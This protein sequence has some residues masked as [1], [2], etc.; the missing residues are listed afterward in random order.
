[1]PGVDRNAVDLTGRR[2]RFP[3]PPQ[4]HASAGLFGVENLS[5]LPTEGAKDGTAPTAFCEIAHPQSVSLPTHP[6]KCTQTER[7]LGRAG[8]SSTSHV[9]RTWRLQ[10]SVSQTQRWRDSAGPPPLGRSWRSW[11]RGGRAGKVSSGLSF[12]LSEPY[13]LGHPSECTG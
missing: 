9:S 12:P 3:L 2:S 1:M 5:P 6:P 13:G 10:W 11:G 7:T 8:W 4:S